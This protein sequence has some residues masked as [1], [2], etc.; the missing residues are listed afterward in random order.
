MDIIHHKIMKA[1]HISA[2]ILQG[3]KGKERAQRLEATHKW[4][5]L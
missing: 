3:L 5:T 2:L 1:E 4:P